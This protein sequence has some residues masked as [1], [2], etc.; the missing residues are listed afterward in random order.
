MAVN[1]RYFDWEAITAKLAGDTLLD[2]QS[3]EYSD[4]QKV[5]RKFGKGR[6][7]RGFTLGN[8]QG[9]GKM[10]VMREDYERLVLGNRDVKS[11]GLYAIDPFEITVTYDKGD[12]AATTDVLEQCVFKKRT[13]NNIQ[14]DTDGPMVDLEFEILGDIRSGDMAPIAD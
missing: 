9:S 11:R 7:P 6:R 13:F 8:V 4:E 2:I 1:G 10:S 14:V 5:V 3:I 12:G